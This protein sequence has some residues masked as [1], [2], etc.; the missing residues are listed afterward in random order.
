MLGNTWKQTAAQFPLGYLEPPHPNSP[1]FTLCRSALLSTL[2]LTNMWPDLGKRLL[3]FVTISSPARSNFA[4]SSSSYSSS[5]FFLPEMDGPLLVPVKDTFKLLLAFQPTKQGLAQIVVRRHGN[6]KKK[7]WPFLIPSATDLPLVFSLKSIQVWSK[8]KRP[9][10]AWT[11]CC[12]RPLSRWMPV[13]AWRSVLPP[14]RAVLPL[15][16][17]FILVCSYTHPDI[18]HRNIRYPRR[19]FRRPGAGKPW[20][21]SSISRSVL[22]HLPLIISHLLSS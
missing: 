9:C 12:S 18:H 21:F 16:V 20:L 10:P 7:R 15:L 2:G 17:A 19:R 4:Y 11:R 1:V 13:A 14:A 5:S 6:V 3:A 22:H 8:R